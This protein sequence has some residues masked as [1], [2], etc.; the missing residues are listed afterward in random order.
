MDSIN[1]ANTELFSDLGR[2]S[3]NGFVDRDE[4]ELVEIAH[5]LSTHGY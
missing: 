2:C 1:G 5:A 3:T 4:R